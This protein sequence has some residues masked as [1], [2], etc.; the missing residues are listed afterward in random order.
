MESNRPPNILHREVVAANLMCDDP[1]HVERVGMNWL[2]G[3]DLP[4]E[5]LSFGQSPRLVMMERKFK[6]LLDGH[7]VVYLPRV[8]GMEKARDWGFCSMTRQDQKTNSK[9]SRPAVSFPFF[10]SFAI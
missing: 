5:R 2:H 1:E 3:E 10:T 6:C 7:G 9:F 8:A 4:I